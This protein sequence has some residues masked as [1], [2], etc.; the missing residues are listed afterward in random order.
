MLFS[1]ASWA[2][3]LDDAKAKGLVG[4]QVNGYLGLVKA[5]NMEAAAL[6]VDINRQRKVKYQ[7]IA[8]KQNT[9]LA[10]IEKIAGEKLVEKASEDGFYYLNSTGGWER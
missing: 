10:N 6:V 7:E 9:Q 4:E 5:D 1:M 8:N 2:L 3:E